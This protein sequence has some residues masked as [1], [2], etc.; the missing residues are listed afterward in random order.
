MRLSAAP[1][2]KNKIRKVPAS[3]KP[4]CVEP[5][6]GDLLGGLYRML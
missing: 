2:R 3:D 4:Y 5:T 1:E 6:I